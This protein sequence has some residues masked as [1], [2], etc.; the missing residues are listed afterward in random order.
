MPVQ[1][2]NKA[3]GWGL[4]YACGMSSSL[5]RFDPRSV[6]VVAAA[7][8]HVRSAVEPARLLPQALRQRFEQP[9]AWVPELRS[10]RRFSDRAPATAAVLLPVVMREQPTLILTQRTDHLSTHSG[11][12]ALPGG[13]VD[14][15]DDGVVHAALREAE[16][17]IGLA[18]DY[19][20]VLG[21][22]P[23]YVTGTAFHV[24]PVVGLVRPG[25]QLHPNP[26]EVAAI[27]EVP[28]SCL[29]DPANHRLHALAFEGQLR[30]WYSMPYDDGREERYIW[31]ATAGM[32]R[33]FYHFLSA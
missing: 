14:P 28:L 31:G 9:P 7:D 22:M 15:D 4:A 23:E 30:H 29:M 21:T 11:Q 33:N 2:R 13:R 27:F 26:Q 18:R 1:C 6:P 10:E 25:F 20:E 24:T 19:V 17:E 8:D 12:I 16:E 3:R 5:P 32:L